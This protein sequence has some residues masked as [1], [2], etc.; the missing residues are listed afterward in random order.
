MRE[1]QAQKINTLGMEVLIIRYQIY[2]HT[3]KRAALLD[4]NGQKTNIQLKVN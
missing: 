3:H 1:I 2:T 4:L